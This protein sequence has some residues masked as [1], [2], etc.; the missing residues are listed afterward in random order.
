MY[1]LKRVH[2]SIRKGV[3]CFPVDN[4]GNFLEFA[5]DVVD[6]DISLIFG[7]DKMKEL[8]LNFNEVTEEFCSLRK[9]ELEVKIFFKLGHLYLL[10][11]ESLA[12]YSQRDLLKIYTKFF[13]PATTKLMAFLRRSDTTETD[14][15]EEKFLKMSFQRA[16]IVKETIFFQCSMPRNILFNHEVYHDNMLVESRP[17]VPVLHIFY[18]GT[19]FFVA[20]FVLNES[21]EAIWN[22]FVSLWVS[23][24]VRFPNIISHDQGSCSLN[25]FSQIN[26]KVKNHS[27]T[28]PNRISELSDTGEK[29]HGPLR[30]IYKKNSALSSLN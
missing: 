6:V 28:I 7:L 26:A 17:H 15:K 29:Y 16:I 24:Y 2:K 20:R 22:C 14:S 18:R 23:I 11:S 30:K 1:V 27:K 19:H 8:N 13:L 3:I 12:L 25:D 21:A 10:W 5:S 9:T 4:H